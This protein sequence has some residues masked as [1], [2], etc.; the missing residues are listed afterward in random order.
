MSDALRPRSS[1]GDIMATDVPT[2]FEAEPV[3]NAAAPSAA[4]ET[5]LTMLFTAATV[6]FVSFVAVVAGLV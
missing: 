5:T 1:K 2:A 6:L 3:E 4:M